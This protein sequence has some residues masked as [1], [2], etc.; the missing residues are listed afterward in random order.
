MSPLFRMVAIAV[1]V[2]IAVWGATV[3]AR[4]WQRSGWRQRL[5]FALLL[6]GTLSM[7]GA[8]WIDDADLTLLLLGLGSLLIIASLFLRPGA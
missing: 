3:S 4:R 2:I 5:V 7:A 8:V 6:A 1:F